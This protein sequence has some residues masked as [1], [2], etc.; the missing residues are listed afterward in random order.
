MFINRKG[1]LGARV[2]R[3]IQDHEWEKI[4]LI[5]NEFGKE[6]FNN[7]K[8]A[9][10]ILTNSTQPIKDL[11]TEIQNSLK[12]KLEG[13]VALNLISG[14]G[15]EHMGG[16]CLKSYFRNRK[17]T[18][19]YSFSITKTRNRNKING[20]N[21]RRNRRII[22]MEKLE[23]QPC[24]FCHKK[25]LTLTEEEIEKNFNINRRRNRYPILR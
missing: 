6:N 5:T 25:T 7:Q 11:A 2:S 18:H 14:T 10:F 9:E 22:K 15:K 12:D 13:D 3:L 16:C 17:R 24:P 20:L 23:N 4:F 19:G 21:K 8:N 1:N